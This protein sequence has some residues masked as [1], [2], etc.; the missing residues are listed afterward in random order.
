MDSTKPLLAAICCVATIAVAT[1]GPA[2]G[3]PAAGDVYTYGL[4]NGYSKEARG[5]LRYEIAKVEPERVTFVVKPDN[6]EV[7]AERTE[8]YTREGNWL[9]GLVE[10]HGVPVRY[11]FATAYPAFVFPLDPGKMWSVRVKARA[12]GAARERSV[13]VDGRVIGTERVRVPAGEFDAIKVRR[14]VYA[15]DADYF[16]T[17]T[18]IVEFDWYA[19][20]LGRVV[21]SERR[22]DWH[23][24]SRCDEDIGCDYYGDWTVLELVEMRPARS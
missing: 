2:A 13:R 6:S 21:R 11:D 20:V 9:S 1:A 8:V 23:D 15:G 18:R 3:A 17:E 19:P 14:H 7:G 16:V 5:Q 24:M 22:S 12:A 4:V 10:S